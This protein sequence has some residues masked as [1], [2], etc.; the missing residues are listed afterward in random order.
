M[1][2]RKG[3]GQMALMLTHGGEESGD[4]SDADSLPELLPAVDEGGP[5]AEQA[6]ASASTDPITPFALDVSILEGSVSVMAFSDATF[7]TGTQRS[8]REAES[9]ILGTVSN[10]DAGSGG[11][12]VRTLVDGPT[13]PVAVM[14]T[15]R[16]G[17]A[18]VTWAL[19]SGASEHIAPSGSQTA[20]T[21]YPLPPEDR[22]RIRTA[23][24]TV[25]VDDGTSQG[26]P[27]VGPQECLRMRGA[28]HLASMGRMVEDS[29]RELRHSRFES[30][31]GSYTKFF[32]E[33]LNIL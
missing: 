12:R 32:P 23:R 5:V 2:M 4:D 6:L 28:Q 25:T 17:S 11:A 7:A 19:D 16:V 9:M 3:S 22:M 8:T 13:I 14:P 18:N 15:Q 20:S 29:P 24:G 26:I 27:Y 31:G 21:A 1:A 33:T 30:W 10:P